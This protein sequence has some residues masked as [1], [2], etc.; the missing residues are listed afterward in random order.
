M[1]FR[2][3]IILNNVEGVTDYEYD[4][5]FP[6]VFINKNN[7]LDESRD[8]KYLVH[9]VWANIRECVEFSSFEIIKSSAE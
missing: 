8:M 2:S 7:E 1:L 5:N 9:S 4:K 6:Y 3:K